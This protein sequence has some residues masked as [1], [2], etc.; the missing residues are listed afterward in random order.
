MDVPLVL[1][2]IGI[3]YGLKEYKGKPITF[4]QKADVDG[5]SLFLKLLNDRKGIFVSL[6]LVMG[7]NG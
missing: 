1:N 2:N 3:R 4:Y 7:T 6:L 5:L